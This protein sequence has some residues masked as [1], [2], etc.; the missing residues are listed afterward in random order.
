MS[1]PPAEISTQVYEPA[2][3]L[4]TNTV[5]GFRICVLEGAQAAAHESASARCS[6]GSQDGNDLVVSES[7]VS[8]FHCEV[9]MN[10][11]G[12]KIRDLGSCNGTIVD[13]V[14]VVE[15]FLRSGS[16]IKLG[17]VTLRFDFLGQT[18]R[19]PISSNSSFHGLV[20]SSVPMRMAL[21]LVERAASSDITVL[22]NG[23]TGTGKGKV[24]EAIHR[25]AWVSG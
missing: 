6:I 8:R 7:T 1:A 23:E 10:G 3:A 19:L 4:A 15:A 21:A 17:A 13:G 16:L 14:R 5:L 2:S 12:A 22:L 20:A 9:L 25:G 18:I 11:A 24:A